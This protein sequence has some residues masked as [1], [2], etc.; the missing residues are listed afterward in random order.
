MLNYSVF[1]RRNPQDKDAAPRFYG[2]V[3]CTETVSL[4]EFA[5]HIASHGSVYSR[6][7]VA[8][9][10]TLAVDCLRE[11]LLKGCKVELGDLGNFYPS[12]SSDSTATAK[13]YDPTDHVKSVNV[14]W[15]RGTL[16]LNLKKD[17]TFNLVAIRS[18]QRAVLK[19]VKNGETVV[20][21]YPEEGEE[22]VTTNEEGGA[23][24]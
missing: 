3:Q 24:E 7:D 8:A 1:Q 9:I 16:F 11:M 4:N 6:A 22:G 17:A 18:V 14:N 12:L 23:E 21:L 13:E 10:L 20:D 2:S 5:K 15:E 19:A